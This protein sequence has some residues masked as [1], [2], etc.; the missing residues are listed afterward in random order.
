M[1][2]DNVFTAT[3][4]TAGGGRHEVMVVSIYEIVHN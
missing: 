3:S 2:T 1:Y 4:A